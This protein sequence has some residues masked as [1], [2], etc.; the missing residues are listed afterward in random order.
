MRAST[1]LSCHILARKERMD[2][3]AHDAKSECDVKCAPFK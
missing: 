2:I 1:C 3:D